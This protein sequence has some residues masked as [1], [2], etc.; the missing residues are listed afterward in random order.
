M[1]E[2]AKMLEGREEGIRWPSRPTRASRFLL[3]TQNDPGFRI[4]HAF[5]ER[6]T[7]RIA[8]R[9]R[10]ALRKSKLD[11]G[12]IGGNSYTLSGAAHCLLGAS[13]SGVAKAAICQYL[14]KPSESNKHKLVLCYRELNKDVAMHRS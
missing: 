8:T 3:L 14:P 1:A 5:V 7:R 6:V 10:G 9:C 4:A 13:S 12:D 2:S 11:R